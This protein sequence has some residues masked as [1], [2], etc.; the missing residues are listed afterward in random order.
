MLKDLGLDHIICSRSQRVNHSM[1]RIIK[2]LS[3][4]E[5]FG[6]YIT[7]NAGS[8]PRFRWTHISFSASTISVRSRYQLAR[9]DLNKSL[10][11]CQ[12]A[13][14][15][16]QLLTGATH[17]GLQGWVRTSRDESGT[18]LAAAAEIWSRKL[19]HWTFLG[20]TRC[21]VPQVLRR[22]PSKTKC[23]PYR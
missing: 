17:S 19:A 9:R 11:H 5:R 21:R 6:S 22:V 16:E 14:R 23:P 8:V 2:P 18:S 20:L 4:G 1:S 15:D 13:L 12:G 3:D 10:L 7:W